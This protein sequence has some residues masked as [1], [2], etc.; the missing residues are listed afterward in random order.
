MPHTYVYIDGF[1]LYYGTLKRTPYKWLDLGK[2]CQVMLPNDNITSIQYFTARVSARAH[3]TSAP[4]DQ[5]VYLRALR[6]VPNL[7][8]TFGHFLTHSVPMILSGSNPPKRV[9]VEKTEEKGSDVNLAAHLL[10]DA[11]T[12]RF[13]VAVLVTNDSDLAEPVRIVR[14]EL[15]LPVGILN[16]HR[17]H[18]KALQPLATFLKRIRQA[19]LIASQFPPT[20]HDSKGTFTKPTSW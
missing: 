11:Y 9:F 14:Q 10:R 6:T 15:I 5:Q 17:Y 1:N 7:S 2:L 4:L 18:S 12:K 13:D 16:P 20:M 19:D 8:I 3:N